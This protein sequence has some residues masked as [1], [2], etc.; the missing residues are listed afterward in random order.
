MDNFKE[1]QGINL[2]KFYCR[3]TN[4][5]KCNQCKRVLPIDKFR[6][7][8]KLN[9]YRPKCGKCLDHNRKTLIIKWRNKYFKKEYNYVTQSKVCSKCNERKKFKEYSKRKTGLFGLRSE[10]KKCGAK[11]TKKW[12][13][14]N[15]KKYKK[16]YKKGNKRRFQKEE[17]REYRKKYCYKKYHNDIQHKLKQNIRNRINSALNGTKKMYNSK[18]ILGCTIKEFK[19]HLEEQFEEGMNW[20][21][22]SIHGW[23]IDHIKPCASFD[24]TDSE[25]QKECFH[26]T[27]TQPLWAKDN[28]AKHDHY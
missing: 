22:W 4:S 25:Q 28:L 9:K 2:F 15:P 23:H 18:E 17:Y 14:S 20:D 12:R 13:K 7:R 26:Y 10:C 16:Q 19:E 6:F 27:N 3:L 1:N 5:K 8:K 21:N 11:L 24:L